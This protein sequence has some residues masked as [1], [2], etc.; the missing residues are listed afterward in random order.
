MAEFFG[1]EIKRKDADATEKPSVKT[2]VTDTEEDGAGVI[3]AA[4]HFGSY[5]D[6]DGND[7]KN[8][9]DLILKYRDVASHPM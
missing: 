8:E 7:Q 6:L 4:G 1:F 2:F 9:A 3:K 5:L